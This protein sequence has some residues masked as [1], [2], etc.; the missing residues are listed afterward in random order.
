[1]A[2]RESSLLSIQQAAYQQ[3]QASTTTTTT[4]AT[5]AT[6]TTTANNHNGNSSGIQLQ[7]NASFWRRI[8]F[9]VFQAP[10]FYLYLKGPDLN[11]NGNASVGFWSGKHEHD[12]CS[13]LTNIAAEHWRQNSE[14]CDDLIQRRFMTYYVL[15]ETLIYIVLTFSTIRYLLRFI[16]LHLCSLIAWIV[17][18]LIPLI[19]N[20]LWYRN[21]VNIGEESNEVH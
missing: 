7:P 12:I 17:G 8:M 14:L 10:L 9:Y 2:S 20:F 16:V 3:L 5:V 11:V 15:L 4:A 1:M 19:F 13:Q 21:R 6:G 18:T